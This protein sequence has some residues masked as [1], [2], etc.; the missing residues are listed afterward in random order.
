MN[1]SMEQLDELLAGYELKPL[2]VYSKNGF[3]VSVI[4]RNSKLAPFMVGQHE[5]PTLMAAVQ[6]AI[7]QALSNHAICTYFD[8]P[9]AA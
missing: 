1:L 3:S 7:E 4:A 2:I 8:E 5:A 9:E 6:G